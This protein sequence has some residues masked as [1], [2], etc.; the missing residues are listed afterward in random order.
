MP[1]RHSAANA[2]KEP[3]AK[4]TSAPAAWWEHT[5]SWRRV[6]QV[7]PPSEEGVRT[8]VTGTWVSCG[9]C[10]TGFEYLNGTGACSMHA[11][12]GHKRTD[13]RHEGGGVGWGRIFTIFAFPCCVPGGKDE[14]KEH[15]PAPLHRRCHAASPACGRLYTVGS[16][17]VLGLGS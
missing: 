1:P 17:C 13:W 14:H 4:P 5:S 15:G 8:H 10:D 12:N 9:M 7:S 16:D 6:W 2:D 11:A 3:L